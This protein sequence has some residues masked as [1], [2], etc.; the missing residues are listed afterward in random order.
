MSFDTALEIL[1]KR[2]RE[3]SVESEEELEHTVIAQLDGADGDDS[4]V[5]PDDDDNYCWCCVFCDDS[6]GSMNGLV[7]HRK[8]CHRGP[9]QTRPQFWF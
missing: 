1:R 9:R 5:E 3:D 4:E 2:P 8:K 6:G 7:E